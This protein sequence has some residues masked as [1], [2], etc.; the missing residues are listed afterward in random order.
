MYSS[1]SRVQW[2]MATK[3]SR[4]ASCAAVPRAREPKTLISR[5]V[6]FRSTSSLN[7]RAMS[8]SF[9]PIRTSLD[10]HDTRHSRP[11][12]CSLMSLVNIPKLCNSVN[13]KKQDVA[14]TS[15][16]PHRLP[17]HFG[18]PHGNL[19]VDEGIIPRKEDRDVV[20][21]QP[22]QQTVRL[23]SLDQHLELP[24]EDA[25]VI[26]ALFPVGQPP[27]RL[28]ARPDDGA[29]H[30]TGHGCGRRPRAGGKGKD[31]EV[32]D[33]KRLDQPEGLVEFL[34]RLAGESGDDVAPDAD[35]RHGLRKLLD[36]LPEVT[37]GIIPVHP[38][39]HPVAPALERD[40]EVGTDRL[41]RG[42]KTGESVGDLGR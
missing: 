24:A 23:F 12:Q 9:V 30:L 2:S 35:I 8:R 15:L 19:A 3:M 27:E 14:S 41:C 10:E 29:V 6:T 17:H 22:L 1:I 33:G 40:V 31:V 11:G 21:R 32:G 5:G 42:E 26:G 7:L 36:D 39:Q 4:S 25:L 34:L 20:P 18:H 13:S 37:C 38:P 16:P 28:G